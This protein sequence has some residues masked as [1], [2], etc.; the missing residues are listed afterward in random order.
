M[1]QGYKDKIQTKGYTLVTEHKQRTLRPDYVSLHKQY[2]ITR[3]WESI[4]RILGDQLFYHF[5]KHYIVS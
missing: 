3:N 2:I 1:M 5:Y 4:H